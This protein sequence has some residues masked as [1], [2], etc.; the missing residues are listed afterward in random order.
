MRIAYAP[1]NAVIKT[2]TAVLSGAKTV[3]ATWAGTTNIAGMMDR[4]TT[5]YAQ[6]FF[7]V[8]CNQPAVFFTNSITAA[9]LAV[10]SRLVV[11]GRTYDVLARPVRYDAILPIHW[12]I[13]T[14]EIEE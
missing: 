5:E 6:R 9:S 13:L 1:H 3:N 10:G 4:R 12:E 11:A 14:K 8:E 7:G 2:K